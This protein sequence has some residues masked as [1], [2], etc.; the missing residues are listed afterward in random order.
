[1]FRLD[2]THSITLEGLDVDLSACPS[3]GMTG[4]WEVQR[5]I[6]R[7]NTIRGLNVV[8]S[9]P[10]SGGCAIC[11][12]DTQDTGWLIEGNTI[13]DVTITGQ[14]EKLIHSMYLCS[15]REPSIRIWTR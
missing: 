4:G 9:Q 6:L 8:A 13:T 3:C 10:G 15:V 12:W 1:V 11:S 14:Y 5:L 7:H 2:T